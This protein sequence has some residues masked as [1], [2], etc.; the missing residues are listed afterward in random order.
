MAGML[1]REQT[2]SLQTIDEKSIDIILRD[3]LLFKNVNLFFNKRFC[4]PFLLFGVPVFSQI[5]LMQLK[6]LEQVKEAAD[7]AQRN[8]INAELEKMAGELVPAMPQSIVNLFVGDS[9]PNVIRRLIKFLYHAYRYT[10]SR[11]PWFY[12]TMILH[13][14]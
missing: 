14:S 3:V 2:P 7:K 10:Q 9:F 12:L 4:F 8:K 6:E 13:L 1:D 5:T 11:G